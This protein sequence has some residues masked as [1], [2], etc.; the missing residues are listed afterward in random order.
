[1]I[2]GRTEILEPEDLALLGSTFDEAWAA[3]SANFDL[4][5]EGTRAEA[6]TRLAG[7]LLELSGKEASREHI[8]QVVLHVFSPPRE[9]VGVVGSPEPQLSST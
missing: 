8:R 7:L 4:A 6:R 2:A 5:D 9:R 1:M 3:I